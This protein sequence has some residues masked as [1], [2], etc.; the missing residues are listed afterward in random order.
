MQSIP[1]YQICL[2]EAGDVPGD[3][4]VITYKRGRPICV[5]YMHQA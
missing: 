4:E 2:V 3:S 5:P 1:G